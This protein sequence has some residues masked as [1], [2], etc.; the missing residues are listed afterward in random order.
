MTQLLEI[1]ERDHTATLG[2]QPELAQE[3]PVSKSLAMF[4]QTCFNRHFE[5]ETANVFDTGIMKM[6]VR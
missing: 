3:F 1:D 4:Q 5:T 6:Q 2:L